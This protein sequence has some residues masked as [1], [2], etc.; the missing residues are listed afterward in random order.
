M[1]RWKMVTVACVVVAC[2]GFVLTGCQTQK[3]EPAD[4]NQVVSS[5]ALGKDG[6]LRVG[7][8]AASAPLAG[9]TSSSSRIVG[10]DV[11]AAAYLADE[12]GLD[13]EI[14]DVGTDP[15]SALKDNKVDIVMGVDE[16]EEGSGFWRSPSYLSTGVAL[17]SAS[18]ENSI[19]TTDSKPKIAAQVSSKSSWRVT[20]LFGNDSLVPQD[21]LKGAFDALKNG[22]ARYT[23]ADAVIGTYVANSNGY[24]D[25]IVALLQ[26]PSGYC[27]AAGEG[28]TEL[29]NAVSESLNKL[30]NGGMMDVIENKWLGQTL[31]LKGITVIKGGSG[32]TSTSASAPASEPAEEQPAEG[33]SAEGESGE[34]ESG[35]GESAE[36]Q[37]A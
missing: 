11:D 31:D 18:N 22:T 7:V 1:K 10:I 17:F 2:L 6:V 20:N 32:D 33:E 5:S 30:V 3:Y 19:P 21:N 36:A 34:G 9:Q 14:V 23:A 27:V 28:N 16:S 8:N 29:Q 4:K 26:D 37:E 15:A 24:D 12:L 25:K 13:L 35:E